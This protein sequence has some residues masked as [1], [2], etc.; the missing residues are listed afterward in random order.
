MRTANGIAYL[1]LTLNAGITGS[2]N[3]AQIPSNLAPGWGAALACGVFLDEDLNAIPTAYI[4]SNG[5]VWIRTQATTT[6]TLFIT[7]C[8]I[9]KT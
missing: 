5:A 2:V 1:Q 3:V 4:S 9:I 6:G 7:G 8:W